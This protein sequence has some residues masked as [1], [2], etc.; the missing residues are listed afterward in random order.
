LDRF[1]RRQNVQHYRLLLERVTDE[2]ERQRIQKLIAEE[3]RKQRDAGDK[4]EG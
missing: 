2:A 3:E 4:L 1:I